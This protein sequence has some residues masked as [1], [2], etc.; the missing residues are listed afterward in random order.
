MLD[1]GF[2]K[3]VRRILSAMP[4]REQTLL[5]SAT[6]PQEIR[7]LANDILR[8][9]VELSLTPKAV[10]APSVTHSVWH[11]PHSEK[12]ALIERLLSEHKEKRA[13]VFSRTK[14]AADRI[15]DRLVRAGIC[16]AAIHGNK[17]QGARER[18][19]GA[20]REGGVRVL[21]ATDLAARGIDVDDI[22]L[23]INYDLPNV[24]ESYVH[25]IGRTGRAGKRGVAMSFCD[26][27]ERT[28][29]SDIERLL[30]FRIPVA[31]SIAQRAAQ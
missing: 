27:S 25:R 8:D 14:H 20:F 5:L 1:M 4:S 17:S 23:V 13:I 24:A 22:G 15:S 7:R 9:P 29:L 18:A 26:H 3:D 16:A 31:G 10:A 2:I 6:M 12:R 21:V 28:L 11:V 30:R 19:L